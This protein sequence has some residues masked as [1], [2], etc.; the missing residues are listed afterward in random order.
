M[1]RTLFTIW[2]A[3]FIAGC[4]TTQIIKDDNFGNATFAAITVTD[5]GQGDPICS[6]LVDVLFS[7]KNND[8]NTV[9]SNSY[10]HSLISEELRRQ[11]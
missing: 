1:K 6:N 3:L 8:P 2:Y 5:A 7:L 9:K 4:S 10:H 11:Q